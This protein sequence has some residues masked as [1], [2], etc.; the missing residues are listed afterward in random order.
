MRIILLF[1]AVT[2]LFWLILW[3]LGVPLYVAG[4]L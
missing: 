3:Q 4:E 2:V 1:A